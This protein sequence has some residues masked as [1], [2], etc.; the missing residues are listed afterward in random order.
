VCVDVDSGASANPDDVIKTFYTGQDNDSVYLALR[1]TA[2]A[3]TRLG[4]DWALRLYFSHRHIV[5]LGPPVQVMEDPKAT[6]TRGG[7]VIQMQAGGAAREIAVTF[8]SQ[9]AI[10]TATLAT[11]NGTGWN[12]ASATAN[13]EAKLGADI[14]ELKVPKATLNYQATDPLEMLVS[15]LT[16]GASP[17]EV[18]RA[19]NLNAVAIHADRSKMVEVNFEV[20]CTGSKLALTAVKGIANPPPPQGTGKAFIVGSLPELGNWTP[21]TVVM[22]DD[23]KTSG[24]AIAGDNIWTFRLLVPPMTSIN[25]KYTIGAMGESWGPTE[26]Y[27]LTNRLLEAKDIDGD[28]KMIIRDIFADRPEP[29]G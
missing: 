25:Y 13:V 24:D 9:G 16:L 15:V 10:A 1:L 20:D 12:A 11:A 8:N 22:S 7:Q 18:D 26:E 21:N 23:G 4:T 28:G 3:K 5:S 27:P 17:V 6:I 2:G 19:P 14:L 29:S